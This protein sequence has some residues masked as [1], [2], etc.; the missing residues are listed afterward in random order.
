MLYSTLILPYI[1]YRSEIWGNTYH[2]SLKKLVR[3]QNKALRIVDGKS[4]NDHTSPI[5][6]SYNCL[7]LKD[8]IELKTCT[9][10]YIKLIKDCYLT[11]YKKDF[12]V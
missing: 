6:V 1:N 12:P 11:T 3:L 4:Y 2:S 9:H 5:F 7:K 10:V 8:I